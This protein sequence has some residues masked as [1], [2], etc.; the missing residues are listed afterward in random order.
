MDLKSK[1]IIGGFLFFA[2]IYI[3]INV[4][5]SLK[6]NYTKGYNKPLHPYFTTKNM[7]KYKYDEINNYE[8]EF[9]LK[10]YK[11]FIYKGIVINKYEHECDHSIKYIDIDIGN[12]FIQIRPYF[13]FGS[14]NCNRFWN[15]INIGDSVNKESNSISVKVINHINNKDTIINF[16]EP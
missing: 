9:L 6:C 4:F 3:I 2:T 10:V 16:I 5:Q 1:L 7:M 13:L 14:E 12:Y 15:N 8:K 11:P